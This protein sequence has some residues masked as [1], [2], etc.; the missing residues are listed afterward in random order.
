MVIPKITERG[1][2]Q[3]STEYR[4]W[5]ALCLGM[6]VRS[7]LELGSGSGESANYM[8]YA[9]VPRIV[10]V[11]SLASRAVP[12]VLHSQID[13]IYMDSQDLELPTR[14]LKCLEGNWPDV[15]FI[16]ADH[17][18]EAVRKDFA[19]WWPY[20]KQM[21]AFHDILMPTVYPVWE[22]LC[23]KIPSVQIVG[24]DYESANLWQDNAPRDGVLWCGGIG[25]L[26]KE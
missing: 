10:T 14:V 7:Y 25:V 2:D 26:F 15:V 1:M 5:A 9:G 11:D 16:D 19:L 12:R 23:L 24:R 21:V 13:F 6:G 18:A 3:R 20:A 4:A 22:E 8:L 17:S